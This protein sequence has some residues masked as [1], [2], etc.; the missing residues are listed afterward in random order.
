MAAR[1][2]QSLEQ[3]TRNYDTVF[4]L[5]AEHYALA[6]GNASPSSIEGDVRPRRPDP[7]PLTPDP[8]R[9]THW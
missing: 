2:T 8:M 9:G 1:T 3:A 5:D 6:A 4:H 7:R